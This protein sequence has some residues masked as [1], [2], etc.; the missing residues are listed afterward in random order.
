M[1][2]LSRSQ[3]AK[4]IHLLLEGCSIRSTERLTGVHRDTI[5]RLMVRAGQHCGRLMNEH[6]R[7]VS[8]RVLEV[9]EAWS[10]VGKKDKHLKPF[11][12]S[13]TDY[14]SQWVFIAMD[15]DTKLIP[16]FAV[17][18]RTYSVAVD[19]MDQLSFRISGNTRIVTDALEAYEKAIKTIFE[20]G[21]EYSTMTK[22]FE[23]G[24]SCIWPVHVV[25][26]M[27]EDLVS[28]SLIERQNLTLR[29][30]VRRMARKTLCFSKKLEN[31]KAAL[32]I[33][34]CWYNFGRIHGTLGCTPAMEAGLADSIWRVKRL[35]PNLN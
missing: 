22:R 16:A 34:F 5:M 26:K 13:T 24:T 33:H 30:F 20:S 12:K 29:N 19:L 18:R 17:G 32:S 10:Y 25:G 7:N 6:I 2:C 9:D 35:L 31:L 23:K 11:E 8:P 3:Q 27:D 21:V 28:T 14:G 15:R 1:N 4:V